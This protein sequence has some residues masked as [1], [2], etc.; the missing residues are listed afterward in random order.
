MDPITPLHQAT[1]ILNGE[2]DT[3]ET[4]H[5]Q[6]PHK[7]YTPTN[8]VRNLD[9]ELCSS[10]A[11]QVSPTTDKLPQP[12]PNPLIGIFTNSFLEAIQRNDV[13]GIE[14]LNELYM[15]AF[16]P[17][18]KYHM[19]IKPDLLTCEHLALTAVRRTAMNLLNSRTN[20][21]TPLDNP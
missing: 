14:N 13:H 21:S 17:S 7:T 20:M 19:K 10:D 9:E 3:S 15:Q 1:L 6:E 16:I 2:R 12:S 4:P 18:Y 8:H 11:V 5:A